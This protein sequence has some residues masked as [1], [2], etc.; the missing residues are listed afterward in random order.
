[1]Y[2]KINLVRFLRIDR[3]I[4]FD[5]LFRYHKKIFGLNENPKIKYYPELNF[6]TDFFVA[7]WY[8]DLLMTDTD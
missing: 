7:L 4:S 8:V 1:M 2:L 5:L 3:H 6:F